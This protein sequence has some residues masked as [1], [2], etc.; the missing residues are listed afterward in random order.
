MI[1]VGGPA[2]AVRQAMLRRDLEETMKAR[3]NA[4]AVSL[5]N[6]DIQSVPSH[7]GGFGNG[8]G[9]G[10]PQLK[11]L[12]AEGELTDDQRLRIRLALVRSDDSIA[13]EL[14]DQL[15]TTHLLNVPVIATALQPHRGQNQRNIVAGASRQVAAGRATVPRGSRRLRRS[16]LTHPGGP[17]RTMSSSCVNSWRPIQSTNPRSETCC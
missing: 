17:R 15:L 2:I 10:V 4:Q 1:A 9:F 16:M 7:S 8:S 3:I 13:T 6:A 5:L 14:V 11:Q 12:Q